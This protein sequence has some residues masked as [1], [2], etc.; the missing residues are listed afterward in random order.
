MAH[1]FAAEVPA[2]T[3][4][5]VVIVLAGAVLGI[6]SSAVIVRGIDADALAIAAWR[7]L[8]ASLLLLPAAR[9]ELARLDRRDLLKIGVAGAFLGL[10]F[11]LWFASLDHT[12]VLRSTVMVSTVPVWTGIVEAL[13]G[14]APPRRFWLG[15]AV[16][17]VGVAVLS[18]GGGSGGGWTGDAL[19]AVAAMMWA[20][21][22]VIGRDVRERVGTVAWMCLAC[23]SAAALLW[24]AAALTGVGMVGFPPWT[25]L[26]LG[27]AILGP[28]LIGHQGFAYAVRFLPAATIAMVAL[29]EPV[30]ATLLAALFLGELPG[31]EAVLG[32]AILLCGVV[33]ATWSPPAAHDTPTAEA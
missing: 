27:L 16:A 1:G 21:Y 3:R 15:T 33:W 17:I 24:P 19:A 13:L 8:G 22:F 10:H 29:L 6:S 18:G 32:G 28:Q 23:A 2:A 4:R 30:G 5:W 14:R 26:L 31:P 20:G 11:W 12:T 7:T 25:W 9:S